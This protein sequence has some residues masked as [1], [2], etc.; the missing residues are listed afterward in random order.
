MLG[1]VVFFAVYLL[2][3]SWFTYTAYRMLS[4]VTQGGDGTVPSVLAALPALFFAIFLWKALLF[5]RQ[6]RIDPGIEI[7]A[8]EQPRL[9]SFLHELADQL[10]APRPHRVFIAPGVTA[11]VF[12]DVSLKNLF[13]PTRKNL[14]I[15]L[16]LVNAL[17][18]TE[19]KAVIAHEF[20]HF[21]QSSM[22]VGQWVSVGSRIASGTIHDRGWLD[23][24]LDFISAID[25]RVAWIGWIMRM[26]VWS[27]RSVLD[28]VFGWVMLS[29]QAL[30]REMEFE[31]D[32]IAVS[33]TGSD[34]IV[35][36]LYLLKSAD[37]DYGRAVAF[38]H[39]QWRVK[40]WV[41]NIYPLQSA[42][43]ETMSRVLDEPH[44]AIAPAPP[45]QDPA[46]HRVFTIEI[47]SPPKMWATH[48]LNSQREANAKRNYVASPIDPT[49]AWSHFSNAD[50]LQRQSTESI[51]AE[52]DKPD[53]LQPISAGDAVE[54]FREQFATP[55]YQPRYRGAYVNRFVTVAHQDAS[56]MC[57]DLPP[58]ESI[59]AG[60]DELYPESLGEL[61]R[62]RR[63]LLEEIGQLVAIRNG[64][65]DTSEKTFTFRGRL[66]ERSQ[67]H[68]LIRQVEREDHETL[69]LI[70]QHD[71]QCRQLHQAAARYVAHRWQDYHRSLLFL[72]HHFEHRQAKLARLHQQLITQTN[73]AI[74]AGGGS[75]RSSDVDDLLSLA[76]KLYLELKRLDHE[77][78]EMRLP[79]EIVE[80][81]PDASWRDAIEPFKADCPILETLGPWLGVVD[82]WCQSYDG[83]LSDLNGA[84]VDQVLWLEDTIAAMYRRTLE[85]PDVNVIAAPPDVELPS[86]TDAEPRQIHH[87]E[88]MPKMS[89]WNQFR[90]TQGTFP[91][92]LRMTMAAGI[93]AVV[94]ATT[95]SV[96]AATVV[97][98]NGLNIPVQT[99][100][101]STVVN[102][103]PH[104][105]RSVSVDANRSTEIATTTR[106]GTL[107]ESFDA[108]TGQ[109]FGTYVYNIAG[110]VP[111]VQW[112][113]VYGNVPQPPPINLGLKRFQITNARYVFEQP[114]TQIESSSKGG[115]RSVIE[116]APGL[117]PMQLLGMLEEEAGADKESRKQQLIETNLLWA[118]PDSRYLTVWASLADQ[119]PNIS[120]LI[121]RRLSHYPTDIT[122]RRWQLDHAADA[123]RPDVIR[124]QKALADKYPDDPDVR[125]IAIRG[126]E[127]GPEQDDAFIEGARRWPIH[128]WF[129]FAAAT[130]LSGQL[131]W[132]TAA[133]RFQVCVNARADR[134]DDS[135]VALTRINRLI[136]DD[137]P[138]KLAYVADFA[139]VGELLAIEHG[140]SPEFRFEY[141]LSQGK[142]SEAADW[143][144]D[145]SAP[146][147]Y[148]QIA[149]AASTA[150]KP[151]W[152]ETAFS[153]EPSE[154]D[155]LN[156]L[157]QMLALAQRLDRPYQAYLDRLRELIP[158]GARELSE[159]IKIFSS[160]LEPDRLAASQLGLDP[161]LR[162]LMTA[163][164]VIKLGENAPPS[165][166][167]DARR[168]LFANERPWLGGEPGRKNA[169]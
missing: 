17:N 152:I 81:L 101:A 153:I 122:A 70:E 85:Q 160:E 78:N 95:W 9:F 12:H 74:L 92:I 125:Y 114:P 22:A 40:Q 132:D 134:S 28:F 20:G 163:A 151:D 156:S 68:E 39:S 162:G 131:N 13:W 42:V 98:Y 167:Q 154:S 168:L 116:A 155:S 105:H 149:L 30:S 130:V 43:T 8:H 37:E 79:P 139:V 54:R 84:I 33:L 65:A 124:R 127:Q 91:K 32:D 83:S 88:P 27:I 47:A 166:R 71:L 44:R 123:D 161:H 148:R 58:R 108:S 136:G 120:D 143:L 147:A 61:V 113:A 133:E 158:A 48:P 169:P 128:D 26:I 45:T 60:F 157:L 86:A 111:I 7:H 36:A 62:L 165:W 146:A 53:D 2:L 29:Q 137:Q 51:F 112:Y 104:Q 89:L 16:G 23:R 164:G 126:M 4:G 144:K 97:I 82:G 80:R 49:S 66:M 31:A 93:M 145:Q 150:A 73:A 72:M 55:R 38:A 138:E 52:A 100:V 129:S 21:S 11:A 56:E 142:L 14:I 141:L 77:S 119:L 50:A 159:A 57:A 34:A 121:E 15:G 75:I 5:V 46:D 6:K 99:S 96:G 19:F 140:E 115:T 41:E 109:A 25:L 76:K 87:V 106:N 1:L 63:E 64:D 3:A 69:K 24:T 59:A 35:D 94:L 102:V 107:I 90:F 118:K 10:E 67:I 103:P 117:H 135:A 110:A 18:R